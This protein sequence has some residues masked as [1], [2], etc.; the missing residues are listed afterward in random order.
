[1]ARRRYQQPNGPPRQRPAGTEAERL[2][3]W[4]ARIDQGIQVRKTWEEEY[5]VRQLEE[6]YL[7]RQGYEAHV[8]DATWFNQFFATIRV[9]IP[10]L[11]FQAP[12]FRVRATGGATGQ[13]TRREAML[14]EALLQQ[15]AAEEDN[16]QNDGQLALLQS[17]FRVGCLKVC[18]DPQLE[19]NPAAGEPLTVPM[20]GQEMAA[21]QAVD[22]MHQLAAEASH[23]PAMPS[24]S[25]ASP[26]SPASSTPGASPG[27]GV[28]PA[29][30]PPSP[31]V[32]TLLDE[33]GMPLTEPDEILSDEIYTWDWVD[34][35]KLIFP[36]QGPN[37]RRWTWIAEEV[38]VTLD[39]ARACSQ[40]P[41]ALRAQLVANARVGDSGS[42]NEAQQASPPPT[43][44]G[45]PVGLE[46]ERFRYV[47]IWDREQKRLMAY[48][49]GQPWSDERFLI[50]EPYPDGIDD[51]PYALLSFLPIVG[52]EPSPWPMP[53]TWNWLPLQ[54]E[55]NDVRRQLTNGA[56]RAARKLLYDQHTFPDAEEARKALGS[57]V[58]ME[59]VEITDLGRPPVML[60]ENPINLDITRSTQALQYD[61]RVITG[62]P[63]TRLSGSSDSKTATEATYTER[64]ANLRDSDEQAAVMTWMASAGQK[65]LQRMRQTLTL[66]RMVRMRGYSDH[67]FAS[68]LHSPAFQQLL[69]QLY[70]PE[71]GQAMPAL[72]PLF[73][74]LQERFRRQFGQERV[75]AVSREHLQ[76]D[77]D[78][79]VIPMSMGVRTLD[80]ER[81]SWMQFLGLLSQSP[82][83]MQS[84]ALLRITASMFPYI[85]EDVIEE[86][87][88]IGQQQVQQQQAMQQAQQQA[89]LAQ[90][91][92]RQPGVAGG[93]GGPGGPGVASPGPPPAGPHGQLAPQMRGQA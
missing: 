27:P 58:D 57:S 83:L 18:Y 75:F 40:F 90:A 26:A 35:R 76:F 50:D 59:A 3:Q 70:G 2:Q 55:Y 47:E 7:G 56:K 92:A 13:G 6:A 36:L 33:T 61:W 79:T 64:A 74:A 30:G 88:L 48:A 53:Y 72:L 16:L 20:L 31:M 87:L 77:A 19:K 42:G 9:Q 67:E 86:L 81:Q 68:M 34:A 23:A 10:G 12:S 84:P 82:L 37:R 4:R 28:S 49:A 71:L 78:V 25:G 8:R 51:D 73:P 39:E 69:I 54:E 46:R 65:M 44:P 1:M 52:P 14:L 15:V 62:S 29:P 85:D 21:Q 22:L 80:A 41:K 24:P 43:D 60:Q 11:F 32:R 38:D 93:G 5:R 66:D 89:M 17:F 91:A 63:G 45:N